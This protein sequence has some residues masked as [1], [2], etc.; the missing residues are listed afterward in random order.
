[1]PYYSFKEIWTPL[2]ILGIR[3]YKCIENDRMYIKFGKGNRKP[4][5]R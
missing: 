3:F 4:I 5:T 2:F 1:M